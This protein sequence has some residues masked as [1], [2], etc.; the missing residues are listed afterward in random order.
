MGGRARLGVA[1][2]VAWGCAASGCTSSAEP[3]VTISGV[4]PSSAYNDSRINLVIA[5]GPFRPI[6][7]IDTR[8]GRET[9]ELGA[10]TAF[11]APSSGLGTAVPA[12]A[13]MWLST[14]QLAAD[15]EDGISPGAY[16]VEVRDPRGTLARL[17]AAFVSLGPDRTSPL[18]TIDEPTA[19]T[20]VNA[21]AEVPVAF[22]ADDGLGYL[23]SMEWKVSSSD[24]TVSGTCPLAPNVH[25]ATCRFLFVVPQPS[26]NGQPLAVVVTASD[27]VTP[28][29]QAE[30]TLAI[31]L[32]PVAAGFTP[33]EG[34][35]AGGTQLS[36]R[37]G[38]FIAGTQVL[39]GGALLDDG[40]LVSDEVIAGTTPAHEPGS[41]PVTVQSGASAV[42]VPG[43]FLF[44]GRPEIRAVAPT[45]GPPGGCTP[46]AIVGKNF[47]EGK[48]SVWFG[49]D[50]SPG[51]LLRCPTVVSPNRIE[52][53]VPAG[54]G[55]V[56]VF[57]GDPTGGVSNL[58]L[59]FTY[60]D[61]VDATD[62]G[63]SPAAC[64]CAGGA[65]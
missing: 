26:L 60:L 34:P 32:P 36:V 45:K 38:N 53:Y 27:G 4:T 46:I 55:A 59:G 24:V 57:V 58:Y 2:F 1:V 63:T 51:A 44:V 30:T 16:D 12:D 17:P 49:A 5:G 18:V 11:L 42:D 48:T 6:Y 15:L 33:S 52:G 62:A 31:G 43:T 3:A 20:I 7:D 61:E 8:T 9:T 50:S 13:I 64:P 10:F 35:A 19:A 65:P 47:R 25:R 54:A 14:S 40:V 22:E 29:A 37:G 39:V 23:A 21:G 41:V 28:R 56:S